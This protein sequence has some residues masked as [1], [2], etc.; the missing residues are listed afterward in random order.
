VTVKKQS[1]SPDMYAYIQG[2]L[3]EKHPV[4][5]I[6][7][8]GGVGYYLNISLNTYILLGDNESCRLYT[9]YVVRE[10]AQLLYGF[11]TEEERDLFRLLISVSGVGPNTARLLLSSM[12]VTELRN[13]ISGEQVGTLKSIKGIGE[14][15][16]QRIIV[17]LK[18]KLE[19]VG[20]DTEKVDETHNTIRLE[21]L[22]GLISLGF[23]KKPAE[24]AVDQVYKL[25]M[26]ARKKDAGEEELSV[27]SLIRECLKIL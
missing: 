25:Q 26:E 10:D 22:S 3:V 19:K 9:H 16:A 4:Y 5:A 7:E 11:A 13:A 20:T 2:K 17:D 14:K 8:A 12:K 18:D 6:I 23:P 21:A 1:T 24:K 27:E 15:S